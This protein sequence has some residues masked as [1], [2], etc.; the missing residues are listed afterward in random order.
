L[1]AKLALE[2]SGSVEPSEVATLPMLAYALGELGYA[3]RSAA[4]RA[5]HEGA[6]T[7]G[8]EF[9]LHTSQREGSGAG[10]DD[11]A[12]YLLVE[13]VAQVRILFLGI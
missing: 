6:R 9:S 4:E 3:G 13:G 5:A 10:E 12:F 2:L 8:L 7:G 1:Y 11:I